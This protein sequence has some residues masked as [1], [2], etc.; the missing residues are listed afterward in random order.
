[1]KLYRIKRNSDNKFFHGF[2][3]INKE[4]NYNDY[5]VYWGPS[6]CF[7]K[8]SRSVWENLRYICSDIVVKQHSLTRMRYSTFINF[9]PTRLELYDVVVN[10]V[11]VFGESSFPAHEFVDVKKLIVKSA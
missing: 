5:D 11:L 3:W 2:Q 9:N 6:G 10:D 7:W 4:N 1:M 8:T